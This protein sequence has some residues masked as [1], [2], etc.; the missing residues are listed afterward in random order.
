MPHVR[1]GKRASGRPKSSQNRVYCIHLDY[2]ATPELDINALVWLAVSGWTGWI[3]VLVGS[4]VGLGKEQSELCPS[5]E[6]RTHNSQV[7]DL[8]LSVPLTTT[9]K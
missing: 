2:R 8:L 1:A 6:C 7:T 9:H 3:H 4:R 5:L